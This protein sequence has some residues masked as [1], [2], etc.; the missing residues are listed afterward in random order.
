MNRMA[1]KASTGQMLARNNF[2][3][4]RLVF[5]SMV[6]LFHAA[7]L[8]Q[9][10]ELGWFERNISA[11]FA[12]QAFFVV[13]GFLVTMS[14]DRS[15]S[16]TDYASKRLLRIF[17]A[18]LT[19]ICLSALLL[20]LASTYPADRYFTDGG[21]YRYLAANL[22]FANFTSPTL[23]GVFATNPQDSA[24]NGSLWT[25]KIELAFYAIVPAVAYLVR[26]GGY[27]KV[28][29]T[30]FAASILWKLGFEIAAQHTHVALFEKLAKQLPGQFCFFAGGA[31][32]YHERASGKSP[33]AAYAVIGVLL[34]ACLDGLALTVVAPAA[35]TC[36]VY[37]LAFGLTQIRSPFGHNDISYGTYLYH[38][39]LVQV[40][41]QRGWFESNPYATITLTLVATYVVAYASWILIERRALAS[42]RSDLASV[43][44]R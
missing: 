33:R 17:P 40:F 31:W 44:S 23:P 18:Y 15:R 11:T 6:V 8:S 12:V 38:F 43:P 27:R 28:L 19:V 5:A 41:V 24:V 30:L 32:A 7:H 13:S 3:V 42:R 34:Y 29:I 36:I 20:S 25:I 21:L 22:V 16:L 9:V 2:D 10:P 39:P 26:R 1:D 4:L 14:F 37:W 35:V